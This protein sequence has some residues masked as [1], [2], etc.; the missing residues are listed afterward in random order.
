METVYFLGID[1]SKKTIQSALTLD[2]IN[3][4][5]MEVENTTKAIQSYLGELKKKFRF[6]KEQLIVCLEHTGIYSYPLLDYLTRTG[7]KVCVESALQIKQSQGMKRGKS[8]QVDARR[9]AQYAYKNHGE[10]RLWKPQRLI[11]QRI[12]ALLVLR[13]RLVKTKMQLATPLDECQ[14]YIEESIRKRMVANCKG[15][16]QAL[17]KDITKIEQ[18]IDRLIQEDDKVKEQVNC[19]SSV[20]GVGKITALNVIVA[21]DEFEKISE[22]KKFA[23]YS[24]VAPFEH[25]SGSS[26]RG[27]TRVSKMANMT[28]KKLL[29]LAAMSAIRYNDDIKEYYHRK[30]AVGKNKMSVINAVRNKLISR[31]FACVKNKRMYQKDY[32]R[33]LV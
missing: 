18:E 29:T 20:V 7:I 17:A 11:I 14:D 15:A 25:T 22:V 10:L 32:R 9:I 33:A 8:D 2:G 6:S 16:L 27:K 13:E 26:I 31:I 24:G 23:C 12:K 28:L 4:F 30:V 5:E 3:M 21:T 19:A 1:I